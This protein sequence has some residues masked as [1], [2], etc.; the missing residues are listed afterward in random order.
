MSNFHAAK[1]LKTL[2]H[3]FNGPQMNMPALPV[4]SEA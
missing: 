3:H 2:S 1:W 4:F